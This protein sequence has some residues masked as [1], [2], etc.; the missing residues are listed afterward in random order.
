MRGSVA[1]ATS[2]A[3]P[4]FATI[5]KPPACSTTRSMPAV[6]CP[7]RTTKCVG[8]ARTRSYSAVVSLMRWVKA[9]RRE[10]RKTARTP[11]STAAM[12]DAADETDISRDRPTA[13]VRFHPR[14]AGAG[15]APGSTSDMVVRIV[16]IAPT[17]L[18]HL[19]L[20]ADGMDGRAVQQV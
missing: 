16:D 20:P 10:L 19:G 14:F 11:E 9:K 4:P 13:M 3:S 2:A 15:F 8:S 18:A 12:T 17:V 1:A 7:S 6:S 5:A